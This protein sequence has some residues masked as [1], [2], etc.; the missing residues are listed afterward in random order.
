[1]MTE[2]IKNNLYKSLIKI[3]N[4]GCTISDFTEFR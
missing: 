3:N 2:S 4:L 1:M